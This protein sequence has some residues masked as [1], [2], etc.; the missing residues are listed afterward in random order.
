MTGF[1]RSTAIKFNLFDLFRYW[2]RSSRVLLHETADLAWI[3][4]DIS[5]QLMNA[6]FK[7]R[8]PA[9]GIDA[10][11]QGTVASFKAGT[12]SRW[13]WW[14]QPEMQPADL[15]KHLE[16]QGFKWEVGA[17]GMALELDEL[18]ESVASPPQLRVEVVDNEEMLSGWCHVVAK[19][20][21]GLFKGGEAVLER[22][23]YEVHCKLGFALP[24]R[25]YVG[26]LRDRAVAASQLFLSSRVGGVYWVASLPE[27]RGKGIGSAITLA[28][29][30]DARKLGYQA[31]ILHA[32]AQ[33]YPVYRRLGF[34]EI[35]KMDAYQ[36]EGV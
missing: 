30:R 9:E 6:V 26:L 5:W 15:G 31:A 28:P 19:S 20:F 32:T 16:N 10:A 24:L 25:S 35:C 33:G 23:L 29:L 1:D 12:A 8:L 36:R 34:R 18:N 21:M 22:W 14:V 4:S 3:Q 27:V 13:R 7:T 2:A 17:P 11:I